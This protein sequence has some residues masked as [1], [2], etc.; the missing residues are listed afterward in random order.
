L[1][2]QGPALALQLFLFASFACAALALAATALALAAA[3]R[4]RSF[5]LAA[6]LAVGVRR[7]AL[8]RAAVAEQLALLGAGLALGVVPG[9]V[10][11]A[12]TLPNVPEFVDVPI[13]PLSYVPSVGALALTV[14]GLCLV[15]IVVAAIG[16]VMLLRA[17]VPAR[18]REAAP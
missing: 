7:S 6:L 9:L 11:A 5:E 4:R 15:V 13:T 1:R 10:A 16:A 14:V 18:L 3:G 17:A 8:L 2:Q 12:V